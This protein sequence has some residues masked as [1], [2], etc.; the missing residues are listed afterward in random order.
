MNEKLK[1][2]IE[3]ILFAASRP[4]SILQL[5]KL[6]N[7]SEENVKKC[8]EELIKEYE[9]SNRAIEIVETPEGFE[10][11][12]KAEYRNEA[13]KVAAFS[14]L[15]L[16]TL[17][18]LALIIYKYPIKQSDIVKIQGNRAY[19]YIRILEKKGL[20]VS[21]KVGNTKVLMPSQNIERY[22]GMKIE[23][24]KKQIEKYIQ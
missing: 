6:V 17:K 3:A 8:L 23:D 7:E 20:I 1:A 18:T 5:S 14:D 19:D 12:I 10:M 21:R 11:R 15:S 16:G 9:N 4:I 13:S 22:F 24:I 2:K